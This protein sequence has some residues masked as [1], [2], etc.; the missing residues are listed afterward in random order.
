VAVI[1]ASSL[2][3]GHRQ[4][5]LLGAGVAVLEEEAR[6]EHNKEEEEEEE[7]GALAEAAN[8]NTTHEKSVGDDNGDDGDDGDAVLEFLVPK[9]G[10]LVGVGLSEW[11]CEAVRVPR[12]RPRQ[13]RWRRS[14]GGAGA[15][16]GEKEHAD[17]CKHEGA[18]DDGKEEEEEEAKEEEEEGDNDDGGSAPWAAASTAEWARCEALREVCIGSLLPAADGGAGQQQQQQQ[19]QQQGGRSTGPRRVSAG[20][21]A[22][23]GV[24]VGD[25]ILAV[26]GVETGQPDPPPGS[27]TVEAAVTSMEAAM[28]AAAAAAAAGGVA[29]VASVAGAGGGGVGLRCAVSAAAH[30]PVVVAEGEALDRVAAR[31]AAGGA[32]VVLRV[33]R[34]R[35]R[36][37]RMVDDGGFRR[38]PS[39]EAQVPEWPASTKLEV[40]AAKVRA[41]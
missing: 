19:Q 34:R 35:V 31:I 7:E 39:A 26:D 3:Q 21:A 5:L 25:I 11:T 40:D 32:R 4:L 30:V 10:G 2:V 13:R 9:I 22:L 8:G 38:R 41:A 15:S 16:S 1:T 29:S 14:S 27:G 24:Q 28:A 12:R 17:G 20:P 36:R 23:A 18:G 6:A 33:L 37:G